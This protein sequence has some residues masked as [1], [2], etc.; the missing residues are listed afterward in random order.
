MFRV[1]LPIL[2]TLALL[3]LLPSV[4]PPTTGNEAERHMLALLVIVCTPISLGAVVVMRWRERRM[5]R[6]VARLRSRK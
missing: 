2:L 3:L 1:T 4:L 5:A 6:I